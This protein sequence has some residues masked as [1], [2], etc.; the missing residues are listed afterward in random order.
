[1][2]EQIYALRF[3]GQAAP[4]SPD[5]HV[6]NAATSA[7]SSTITT[8]LTAAGLDGRIEPAA[9][10]EAAFTSEVTFTG[11]S[12]FQETG[13]ID[14]GH[15]DRLRFTTVGS[16]YLAPSADP[17]RQHGAVIWRVEGGDGRF[18]GASGLITSN[19]FVGQDGAVVDHHFGVLFTPAPA[20]R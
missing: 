13:T 10:G 6:L 20:G 18:A 14:F 4:S 19:F 9:G 1:M 3:T 11:E 15:G 8:V 12:A 2:R 16:G 5:G 17:E 7:R